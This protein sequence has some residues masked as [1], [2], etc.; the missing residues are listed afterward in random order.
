[1]TKEIK[2]SAEKEIEEFKKKKANI[3]GPSTNLGELSEF[4][5]IIVDSIQLSTNVADGDI[6]KH[7]D[8]FKDQPAQFIV[9]GQGLQRLAV[10]AGV[11]W[12]PNETK[13]TS[14]SQKYVAYRAVGCIRKNDGTP[15]CFQAEYDIDI[16]V[17]EDELREQFVEKKKKWDA[18]GW[19]QKLGAD[20]QNDYIEAAIRKELNFKKK[21]KTKIA[22]SGAKNRVIRALLGVKKTYA[23]A[24][25][26]HPFVMPRVV[27][28]PDYSDPDVKRMML[29]AS[30]QAITGVF[31]HIPTAQDATID[32][33]ENDYDTQPVPNDDEPVTDNKEPDTPLDNN[34]EDNGP[35]EQEVF[36]DMSALEQIK[37]LEGI[38][39]RKGYE[40]KQPI[41]QLSGNDR[42]NFC[43]ALSKLP[44]VENAV[45]DDIPY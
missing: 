34:G 28:Q 10:C 7:K 25:L 23:L 11:F 42:L 30:V 17:V 40:P 41:E 29:A 26:Q 6:Y 19:F 21:H 5:K 15:T 18:Q 4:H 22:A 9:S 43:A 35:T 38:A 16:D 31:G 37:T 39:E 27:L 36:Q 45:D 12:N 1:M 24:E 20:G 14:Q 13:A 32:I 2:D 33:P 8:K 44:D 3:L